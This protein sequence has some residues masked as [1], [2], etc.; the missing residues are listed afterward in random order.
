MRGVK[1]SVP[2]T[3]APASGD[4]A[5]P[6]GDITNNAAVANPKRERNISVENPPEKS[7]RR[8]Y[9]VRFVLRF[10]GFAGRALRRAQPA[11]EL[12]PKA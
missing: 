9:V 6:M 1:G 8:I 12:I 2:C 11:M 7:F 4:A 5:P 10:M 3:A